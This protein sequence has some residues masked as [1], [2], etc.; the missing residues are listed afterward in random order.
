M[1]TPGIV[2]SYDMF[3]KKFFCLDKAMDNQLSTYVTITVWYNVVQTIVLRCLS[4]VS[5]TPTLVQVSPPLHRVDSPLW[6]LSETTSNGSVCRSVPLGKLSACPESVEGINSRRIWWIQTPTPWRFF[7]LRLK[8]TLSDNLLY[9]GWSNFLKKVLLTCT[10]LVLADL[11]L[12][13][14]AG[15]ATKGLIFSFDLSM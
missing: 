8:M 9:E 15:R 5:F 11:F 4:S 3:K 13:R 12:N 2:K 14:K 10:L 6:R 1:R 7:G